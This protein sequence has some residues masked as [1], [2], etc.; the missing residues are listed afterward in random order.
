MS[1]SYVKNPSQAQNFFQQLPAPGSLTPQAMAAYAAAAPPAPAPPVQQAYAAPHY[2]A[3]LAQMLPVVPPVVHP[4]V[5]ASNSLAAKAMQALQAIKSTKWYVALPVAVGLLFMC[6]KALA[7]DGGEHH[8]ELPPITPTYAVSPAG[9]GRAAVTSTAA[10]P[11]ATAVAAATVTATATAS[12][13]AGATPSATVTVPP[14]LLA[15]AAAASASATG[16]REPP[17]ALKP[18]AASAQPAG[19]GKAPASE[20]AVRAL[21]SKLTAMAQQLEQQIAQAHQERAAQ[22]RELSKLQ[23]HN[24]HAAALAASTAAAAQPVKPVA[25]AAAVALTGSAAPGGLAELQRGLDPGQLALLAAMGGLALA[26]GGVWLRPR[27]ARS[28]RV[29]FFKAQRAARVASPNPMRQVQSTLPAPLAR[30]SQIVT[31]PPAVTA[32]P[33]VAAVCPAPVARPVAGVSAPAPA[34]IPVASPAHALSFSA[35]YS[36]GSFGLKGPVRDEMQ[37]AFAHFGLPNGGQAVVVADGVG[38]EPLGA[39]AA[40]LA[41]AAAQACLQSSPQVGLSET[42]QAM[43][44]AGKAIAAYARQHSIAYGLRTTLMVMLRVGTTAHYCCLGDGGL[45]HIRGADGVATHLFQPQRDKAGYLLASLGPQMAGQPLAGSLH[46]AAGDMLL[47]G[48]DGIWERTADP[49]ALARWLVQR[50]GSARG[51]VQASLQQSLTEFVQIKSAGRWVADD[52]A[53]IG[54][55]GTGSEPAFLQLEQ[56]STTTQTPTHTTKEL[57]YA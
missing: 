19:G 15:G 3:P 26:G 27:L 43:D 20:Q 53:S 9:V 46:L 18:A 35:P 38:G 33:V 8:P 7:L 14:L 25:S 50:I 24:A 29:Q 21:G 32:P 36:L 13:G 44:A 47:S 51:D 4:V 2:A 41:V 30:P 1:F 49:G 16:A 39:Q 40:Q 22:T 48:S 56:V 12:S 11:V 57:S 10:L 34:P 54:C 37:D 28:R 6:F 31:Q 52:N 17:L 55:L 23:E 5:H 45:F 42:L